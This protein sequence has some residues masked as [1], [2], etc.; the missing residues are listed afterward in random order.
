MVA[1]KVRALLV[2]GKPRDA[3]DLWLMRSKGWHV[4]RPLVARKLALYDLAYSPE[5]LQT[6]LAQVARDW[7]RDLRPLMPQLPTFEEFARQSRT[8]CAVSSS[9]PHCAHPIATTTAINPAINNA[10]S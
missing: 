5:R 7:E 8:I 1:E 9:A 3:Y 10:P 6:A 2:R 4:D